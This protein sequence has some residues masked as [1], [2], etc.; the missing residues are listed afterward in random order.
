MAGKPECERDPGERNPNRPLERSRADT[1]STRL[2]CQ[3]LVFGALARRSQFAA[4]SSGGLWQFRVLL[5][6]REV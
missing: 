4:P 5:S 6:I 1:V 3:T 2:S